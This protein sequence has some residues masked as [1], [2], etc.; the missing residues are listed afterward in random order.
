M[1]CKFVVTLSTFL[2]HKDGIHQKK[3]YKV[4]EGKMC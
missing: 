4:A 2:I 3:E 1:H